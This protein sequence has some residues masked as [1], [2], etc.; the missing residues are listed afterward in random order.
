MKRVR[1]ALIAI[2]IAI[3]ALTAI[4]SASF[5]FSNMDTSVQAGITVVD[6]NATPDI[7]HARNF[8][9]L[10]AGQTGSSD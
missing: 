9:D 6:E 8:V 7:Q 1:N 4:F 2:A 3:G 10:P 5:M